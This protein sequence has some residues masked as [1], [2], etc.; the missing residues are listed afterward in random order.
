MT[1]QELVVR[2][3]PQ[4]GDFEDTQEELDWYGSNSEGIDRDRTP[5]AFY[6]DDDGPPMAPEV[7][8]S[9][10]SDEEWSQSTY[11][12]ASRSPSPPLKS[13][14]TSHHPAIKRKA[15]TPLDSQK[16]PQIGTK[17]RKVAPG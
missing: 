15:S 9:D 2:Q 6:S 1:S 12:D 11:S 16:E 10:P 8:D 17:R 3:P 14:S 5:K 7:K 4:Y 13:I